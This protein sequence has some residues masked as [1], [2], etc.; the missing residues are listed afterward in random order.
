MWPSL[1][2]RSIEMPTTPQVR[3]VPR[4]GHRR[5]QSPQS[6]HTQDPTRCCSRLP[7]LPPLVHYQL[8]SAPERSQMAL[9]RGTAPN[10]LSQAVQWDEAAY[11]GGPEHQHRRPSS[12]TQAIAGQ[13]QGRRPHCSCSACSICSCCSCGLVE[14]SQ[15]LRFTSRE[16]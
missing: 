3:A 16:N 8:C 9:T 1:R 5:T 4:P 15:A 13:P 10:T 12:P 7:R 11:W 6:T 2:Q 14:K